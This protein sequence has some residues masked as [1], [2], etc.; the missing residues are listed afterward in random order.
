MQLRVCA[1]SARPAFASLSE[2][3][4]AQL[5][6]CHVRVLYICQKFNG[7][8]FH[9]NFPL[10]IGRTWKSL[11]APAMVGHGWPWSVMVGAA[12]VRASS[13]PAGTAGAILAE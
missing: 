5:Q 11:F 12:D 7:A 3:C 2:C 4:A 1:C 9:A 10:A 13:W 8:C 6:L